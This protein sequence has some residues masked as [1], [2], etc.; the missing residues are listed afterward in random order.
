MKWVRRYETWF[1]L[2]LGVVA[3][4]EWGAGRTPSMQWYLVVTGAA[5]VAVGFLRSR[6]EAG[7]AG[8]VVLGPLILAPWTAP[9]GDGDELPRVWWRLPSL[10]RMGYA[11]PWEEVPRRAA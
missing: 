3:W 10:R 6:D 2:W 1:G 4:M 9:R 7:F 8:G 5:A 11:K